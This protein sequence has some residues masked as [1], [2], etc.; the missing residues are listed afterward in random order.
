MEV[1]RLLALMMSS[2]CVN[3]DRFLILDKCRVRAWGSY[4][5]RDSGWRHR[6]V[7][8]NVGPLHRRRS[9][10]SSHV[11]KQKQDTHMH[12]SHVEIPASLLK[13]ANSDILTNTCFSH[14]K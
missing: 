8:G 12:Q 10:C 9:G 5:D 2:F 4:F 3:V 13:N 6:S 11:L 1:S 14:I 7:L